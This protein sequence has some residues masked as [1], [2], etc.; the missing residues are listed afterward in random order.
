MNVFRYESDAQDAIHAV[1]RI[2]SNATR[3]RSTLA[4]DPHAWVAAVK[5]AILARDVTLARSCCNLGNEEILPEDWLSQ[6]ISLGKAG[7]FENAIALIEQGLEKD[8]SSTEAWLHLGQ[9]RVAVGRLASAELAYRRG[10]RL[11]SKD[12]ELLKQSALVASE[13]GRLEDARESYGK[14]FEVYVDQGMFREAASV[15]ADLC[16]AMLFNDAL[17]D[18]ASCSIPHDAALEQS[19]ASIFNHRG[20][21]K[22]RLGDSASAAESFQEAKER[23]WTLLIASSAAYSVTSHADAFNNLGTLA[24]TEQRTLEARGY[25]EKALQVQGDHPHALKNLRNL[26]EALLPRPII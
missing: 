20:I 4:A 16:Y 26:E 8:P 7:L 14:A 25:F 23:S 24:W 10:L 19:P 11:D 3:L 2:C 21:A 22:A 15:H 12:P 5:R 1:C 6:A 9:L 13:R 18:A 17:E